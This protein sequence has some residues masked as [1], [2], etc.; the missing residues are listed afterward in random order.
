M[1]SLHLAPLL[2]RFGDECIVVVVVRPLH[3]GF[4]SWHLVLLH[5][6]CWVYTDPG[7]SPGSATMENAKRIRLMLL[8]SGLT[9]APLD[10]T[11]CTLL[12][13][14]VF[15]SRERDKV[16]IKVCALS[17]R[18]CRWSRL[19]LLPSPL[20]LPPTN[21]TPPLGVPKRRPQHARASD[22]GSA[23]LMLDR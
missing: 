15:S 3:A 4:G 9:P 10:V 22:G 17:H 19:S 20:Q 16:T 6:P 7:D 11:A 8:L 13:P 1:C 14:L 12:L 23:K 2:S 21:D 18:D 5:S